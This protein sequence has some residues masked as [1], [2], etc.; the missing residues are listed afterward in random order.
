MCTMSILCKEY[1]YVKIHKNMRSRNVIVHKKLNYISDHRFIM[2]T[3][4][5]NQ[6]TNYGHYD[7]QHCVCVCVGGGERAGGWNH[8]VYNRTKP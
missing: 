8:N 7:E 5:R 4:G 2:Y 3:I 1:I 6:S